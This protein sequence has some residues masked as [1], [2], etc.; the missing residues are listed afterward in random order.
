MRQPHLPPII[1]GLAF[2]C[3][4]VTCKMS[5]I[6][7]FAELHLAER[8]ARSLWFAWSP[9]HELKDIV[10]IHTITKPHAPSPILNRGFFFPWGL[11][12]CTRT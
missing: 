5:V 8:V 7:V 12:C 2:T 9:C 1:L 10:N 4:Q 11:R 3:S 6:L